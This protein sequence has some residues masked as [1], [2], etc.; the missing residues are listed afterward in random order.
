M[1]SQNCGQDLPP[2]HVM[3]KCFC[4]GIDIDKVQ[5]ACIPVP[6]LPWCDPLRWNV[7]VEELIVL[8]D[9]IMRIVMVS[10]HH[11]VWLAEALRG[12]LPCIPVGSQMR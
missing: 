4:D 10:Q 7:S 11:T 2:L 8:G 1:V 5:R 3:Q 6:F 9:A 12:V